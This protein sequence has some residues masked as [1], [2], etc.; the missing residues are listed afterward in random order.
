LA[1]STVVGR[2]L[3]VRNTGQATIHA[4]DLLAALR[5]LLADLGAFP[6]G[7]LVAARADHRLVG[8]GLAHFGAS[9]HQP[10]MTGLDVLA[11]G[12]QA[13]VH[14]HAQAGGMAAQAFFDAGLH[15]AR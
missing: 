15:L 8:R 2:R 10:E 4:A 6:A 7:A 12:F 11:A 5:A 1:T 3:A 14:R 13:V 9:H